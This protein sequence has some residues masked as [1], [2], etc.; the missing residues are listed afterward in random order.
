M[1]EFNSER[2]CKDLVKIRGDKTQQQFADILSVNRSTLSFLE[3]GKQIPTL[4]QLNMLCD[5]NGASIDDYFIDVNNDALIY[6]MGSL[7]EDDKE[8]VD[9]MIERIGIK[10]KY[11]IFVRRSLNGID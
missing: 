2:F 8:K 4:D 10:E 5:K 7:G 6:L 1:K 11:D 9:Q 3:N